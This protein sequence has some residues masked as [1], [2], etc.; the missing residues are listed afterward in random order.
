M[1]TWGAR[2]LET[3][4]GKTVTGIIG[5]FILGAFVMWAIPKYVVTTEIFKQ[6]VENIYKRMNNGDKHQELKLIEWKKMYWNKEL[7]N[8]ERELDNQG[9]P[10]TISQKNYME[11]AKIELNK[12]EKA[13]TKILTALGGE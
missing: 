3:V 8:L 6:K 2:Q 4:L 11:K 12:L 5:V 10:P 1:V 9:T 7:W 13:E